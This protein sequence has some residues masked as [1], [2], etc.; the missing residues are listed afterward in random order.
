[1]SI[2]PLADRVVAKKIEKQEKTAS[3]LYLGES[4]EKPSYAEVVEVGPD[5]K[6]VKKGDKILYDYSGTTVTIDEVE[7]LII[8]EEGVLATV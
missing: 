4:G 5:V 2:K 8:K 1:M 3:G 7:Y 6:T